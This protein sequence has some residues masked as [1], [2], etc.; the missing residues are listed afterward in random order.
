MLLKQ[1]EY[2]S[3]FYFAEKE[4]YSFTDTASTIK[5]HDDRLPT[6][7]LNVSSV[8]FKCIKVRVSLDVMPA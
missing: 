7:F 5:S 3:C 6:C 1:L 8:L 2:I 4:L